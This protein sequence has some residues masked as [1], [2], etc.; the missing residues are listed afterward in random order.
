MGKSWSF[1]HCKGIEGK[2][3]CNEVRHNSN[4]CDGFLHDS[5]KHSNL[6]IYANCYRSHQTQTAK[7][8]QKCSSSRKKSLLSL[9][10]DYFHT[11]ALFGGHFF[12]KS[13]IEILKYRAVVVSVSVRQRVAFLLRVRYTSGANKILCLIY[14]KIL[15]HTITEE[16]LLIPMNIVLSG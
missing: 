12:Y 5:V 7:Y 14:P 9:R 13:C 8:S 6:K 1:P 10:C 2:N 11:S 3:L 16:T 4:S 15:F